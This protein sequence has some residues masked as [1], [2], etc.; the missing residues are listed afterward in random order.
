MKRILKKN[1]EKINN[2]TDTLYEGIVSHT[3]YKPFI[4]SFN[5]HFCYF[6]FSLNFRHKYKFFKKNKFSLFSFYDKDHGEVDKKSNN[7]YEI[8]KKNFYKKRQKKYL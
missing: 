1:D 4:H 8:L 5:Y 2:I 3:R 7:T 6:W